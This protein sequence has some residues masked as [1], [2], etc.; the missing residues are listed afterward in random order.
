MRV[1][2]GVV[3]VKNGG[4]C[5]EYVLPF[6]LALGMAIS[7]LGMAIGSLGMT[8]STCKCWEISL[9]RVCLAACMPLSSCIP[10]ISMDAA[11]PWRVDVVL[12]HR[13]SANQA[14]GPNSA[15]EVTP[16]T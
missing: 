4:I 7:S 13:I 12:F 3:G 8:I 5:G 15:K 14:A 10:Y 11:M 16:F 6:A 9:P 1:R 2:D